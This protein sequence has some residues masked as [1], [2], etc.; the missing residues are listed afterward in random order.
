[1]GKTIGGMATSFLYD[2]AN[3]VQE[4]TS[5]TPTANLLSGGIDEVFARTDAA[6]T[7]NFLADAL[8]STLALSDSAGNLLTQYTYEPFGN[9]TV[10]G[11]P[12]ANPYQHTGREN[13]GTG[14]YFYRARYYSPTFQRFASEDPIG[15]EGGINLYAYVGNDPIDFGDPLG[16]K[17]KRRPRPGKP[18]PP[19]PPSSDK[20]TGA[21]TTAT[22]APSK[23]TGTASTRTNS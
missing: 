7:T 23:A 12:S 13:D 20:A 4:L 2:A 6:G 11:L 19:L 14:L 16:L 8:G 18:R 21:S 9:T 22:T 15:F 5:G 3:F 10:S 1:M 17:P